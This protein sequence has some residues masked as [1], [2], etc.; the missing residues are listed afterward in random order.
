MSRQGIFVANFCDLFPASKIACLL[1]T[2]LN[3]LS[4]SAYGQAP[5]AD[6]S[7]ASSAYLRSDPK[8]LRHV[9]GDD[10]GA[11]FERRVERLIA[12]KY[13][14]SEFEYCEMFINRLGGEASLSPHL[15]V[16]DFALHNLF[17]LPQFVKILAHATG[18]STLARQSFATLAI[19]LTCIEGFGLQF[20]EQ[21]KRLSPSIPDESPGI[22]FLFDGDSVIHAVGWYSRGSGDRLRGTAD[23]RLSLVVRFRKAAEATAAELREISRLTAVEIETE[24]LRECDKLLGRSHPSCSALAGDWEAMR[25]LVEKRF[26]PP[27][28]LYC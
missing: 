26:G 9:L 11:E 17:D 21:D 24:I 6:A 25:E 20:G 19:P 15:D 7:K 8:E 4:Y 27:Q 1:E 2:S 14:V 16:P 18:R 23:V 3:S 5:Q 12:D 28:F 10:A 22:G 13:G